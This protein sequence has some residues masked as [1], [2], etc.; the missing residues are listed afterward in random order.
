MKIYT[1]KIKQKIKLP[2]S[3]VFDFFSNP[4]NLEL[5]TPTNL[6]FIIKTA[7]PIIMKKDLK[8]D[9]QLRIRGIP[10]KWTSLISSYNPP[11]N[12]IDEQVVGPYLLWHHTHRFIELDDSTEIIDIVNYSLPFGFIGQLAH[13]LFV[14]KDLDNI[15]EYRKKIISEKLETS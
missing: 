5:I 4:E 7:P 15:F 2:I 10:I 13:F 14:K 3:E 9:Y 12:F 8:I 11:Y 6:R 1:L